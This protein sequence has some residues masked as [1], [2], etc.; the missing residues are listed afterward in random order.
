MTRGW[1]DGQDPPLDIDSAYR[2]AKP[3]PEDGDGIA[4][5]VQSLVKRLHESGR[6]KSVVQR[7]GK[8]RVRRILGLSPGSP[9]S[10][11]RLP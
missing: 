5:G 10:L 4:V 2:A 7:R 11:G 8:L 9:A 1:Q 3:M 6:L